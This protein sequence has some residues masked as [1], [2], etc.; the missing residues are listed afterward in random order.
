MVKICQVQDVS[1]CYD[2]LFRA[3]LISYYM[4]LHLILKHASWSVLRLG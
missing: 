2:S 1:I 4:I 3:V